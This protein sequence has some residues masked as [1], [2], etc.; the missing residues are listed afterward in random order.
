GYTGLDLFSFTVTDSA[1]APSTS[2]ASP[3]YINIS[4]GTIQ[5]TTIA[6]LTQQTDGSYQAVVTVKNSGTAAAQNAQL[7][8]ATLGSASGSPLP[9]SL[10]TIQPGDT[11]TATISYPATAGAPGSTVVERFTG[12]YTGGSFGGGSRT[13]LP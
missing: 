5:L 2:S 8:A 12:T 9:A 11:A 1:A 7:T 6:S 10:G 4:V 13:V 3:V